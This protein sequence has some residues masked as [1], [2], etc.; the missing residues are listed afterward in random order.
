MKP[1]S[2]QA[3]DKVS[4]NLERSASAPR[5]FATPLLTHLECH[6]NLTRTGPMLPSS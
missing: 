4:I 1:E 6:A 3:I 5:S 2:I